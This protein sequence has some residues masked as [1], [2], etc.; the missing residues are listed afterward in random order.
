[1]TATG[2]RVRSAV[3]AARRAAAERA[4]LMLSPSYLASAAVALQGAAFA[5]GLIQ[6]GA[7]LGVSTA[8]RGGSLKLHASCMRLAAAHRRDAAG[9][10][11]L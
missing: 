9:T 3:K 10:L 6:L 4:E 8:D 1:M 7:L 2:R 5:R 11:P